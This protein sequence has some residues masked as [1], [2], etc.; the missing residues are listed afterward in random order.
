MIT[1]PIFSIF[2]LNLAYS[3][4][5]EENH[6]EIIERCYAP[7]L[8]LAENGGC[9]VGVELTGWTLQRIAVLRPDW[10]SYLKKLIDA[11]KVELIGS[12]YCQIIGP[13]VPYEVNQWNQRLGVEVY[14]EILGVRP[15]LALVNEMA[16]SSGLVSIYKESGYQ[17]I[18]M[19]RDNISLALDI[20]SENA[21]LPTH[22]DGGDGNEL[23]VLWTDSML[24]QKLQQY[25]HGDVRLTD[26]MEYFHKR[27]T[28]TNIPVALYAN[29]AEV[30]DYRPGRFSDEPTIHLQ[31][32]WRRI[33]SLFDMLVNEKG[34]EWQLPSQA[35]SGC[36]QN[37]AKRSA[38]LS[39]AKQPVPVKKQAK[40]N[41]SRWAIT[42]R[43]DLWL[44]TMCHRFYKSLSND[45]IMSKDKCFWRRLCHLWSSDHRTHITDVRWL[46]AN[47]EVELLAS[48]LGVNLGY[49]VDAFNK[50]DTV[51]LQQLAETGFRVEYDPEGI[52]VNIKSND[53]ALTL[54][55][56]RG[57]SIHKLAFRSHQFVPTL[58]TLPHG[59]FDSIELGADFYSG[60]VVIDQV[61][62]RCRITDLEWVKPR[63]YLSTNGLIVESEVETD[64]G[65]IVKQITLNGE[66]LSLRFLF[67]N[68]KMPFGT[69]RVGTMTLLPEAFSGELM[70]RARNGGKDDESFLLNEECFHSTSVSTL[71]TASA[72][73]GASSGQV[74]IGDNKMGLNFSWLPSECAVFPM[75]YNKKSIPA[76]LT[77]LMFSLSELDETAK[78]GG[79]IPEFSLLIEPAII[80]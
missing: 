17:G 80:H 41:L 25:A 14:H 18:V 35:L 51:E 9:Y 53:I 21:Q 5:D 50:T 45:S 56:R 11:N 73:L 57:M 72:G 6:A 70:L 55:L 74:F 30:F 65:K 31:G 63:F 10:V 23:P 39:S 27:L 66:G 12:G 4:I 78:P 36:I 19:D 76:S 15:R 44:N 49:G 38:R 48:E 52:L 69:V 68:W 33:G 58:G 37:Q 60:N 61:L 29:D 46:A 71:V 40:Y 62:K 32:E 8:S 2:H 7:L 42:G 24:F 26:Y 67:P 59:Y 22:A 75:L 64:C 13:L 43:D 16:Y 28:E 54:N 20:H 34:V 47:S 1:K 3:S 77:R 79:V